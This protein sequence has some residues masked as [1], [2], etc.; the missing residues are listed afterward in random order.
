MNDHHRGTT[1]RGALANATSG[2]RGTI[3]RERR[4]RGL[5]AKELAELASVSGLR[6]LRND[7][8][9]VLGSVVI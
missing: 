8:V 2:I 5:S 1:R 9:V 7:A 4:V 6:N 3:E